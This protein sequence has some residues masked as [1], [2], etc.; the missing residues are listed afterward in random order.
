MSSISVVIRCCNE[1]RHIG[2]LLEGVA[3]QTVQPA[4]VVVVDSGSTDRT[5]E[6]VTGFPARVVSIRPQ[7]FT[8]GRS[9][10]H[11]LAAATGEIAVIASAH[12]YPLFDNW[13]E[14]LVAPF[15]D[16]QVAL[17]YGR[18]RGGKT[19]RFSERQVFAQWF[20]RDPIDDQD[21]PF[22]NNANAAIRRSVWQQLPYDESLTGLEDI[23]WARAARARG[24]KLV[25]EAAAEVVHLHDETARQVFDRYRREAIAMKSIFPEERFSLGDF[26]RL[27]AGNVVS[28]LYHAHHDRQLVRSFAD[29]VRFRLMQ[30][31]GTYRGYAQRG[32][33]SSHLRQRFYY[34]RSRQR[35]GGGPSRELV[36][37]GIAYPDRQVE[38]DHGSAD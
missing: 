32:P 23:A 11:G 17:V 33:L 37:T 14:L 29:I 27:F 31:W 35:P 20:G 19:T 4:E 15:S 8:F 2:R 24:L 3:A 18:Q 5:L 38:T 12:V 16:P 22:C 25:Y 26:V 9:L 21:H 13:I 7:E 28:D 34:P 36:G 6:V 10:N 30:F 1:E